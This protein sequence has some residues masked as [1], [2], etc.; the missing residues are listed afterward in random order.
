ML[1]LELLGVY[2]VVYVFC[3]MR[4]QSRVVSV[5]CEYVFC[6]CVTLCMAYVC[7]LFSLIF[8]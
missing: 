8:F 1:G 3:I 4:M 6:D 7:L 5:Y 2:C